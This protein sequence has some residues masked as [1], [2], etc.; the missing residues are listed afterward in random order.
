[1]SETDRTQSLLEHL[2]ELRFRL[3]RGFIALFVCMAICWGFTDKIMDWIRRPISPY[4]PE[5]GL[6]FTGVMDKFMAHIKVAAMGGVMLSCPFW[7]YQIWKFVAPGLYKKEQ[8]YAVFFIIFGSVLFLSGVG[9]VYFFVYPSAF[10]FLMTFGGG[11]DK[12]MISIAEYLSFF[13]MTTMMFGAAFELPL[14]LTLMAML[15]VLDSRF[16][17]DKRR[18]AVVLLAVV[19]AVLTPPDLISM[20]MMLVPLLLLYESSIWIIYFLVERPRRNAVPATTL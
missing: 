15:G 16:L 8:R 2:E 5:G 14:I 7:I 11:P 19:A 17:R 9:F 12:P 4:L 1:V 10:K 3:V 13:V 20:C 18:Y 6:I